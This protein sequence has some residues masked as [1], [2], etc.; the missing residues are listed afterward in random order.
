MGQN[1][2][3]FI[4]CRS[5]FVLD[6]PEQQQTSSADRKLTSCDEDFKIMNYP[7]I[8]PDNANYPAGYRILDKSTIRPDSLSGASLITSPLPSTYS[9]SS[10]GSFLRFD[11][12]AF[13]CAAFLHLF[14]RRIGTFLFGFGI[15]QLI[16]SPFHWF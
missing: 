10:L 6:T 11:V 3:T 12:F 13:P 4:S 14:A 7:A 1:L 2:P 8:R 15:S 16:S 5:N 9:E